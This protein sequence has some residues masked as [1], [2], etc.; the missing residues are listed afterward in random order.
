MALR[1]RGAT[2]DPTQAGT[3]EASARSASPVAASTESARRTASAS[4]SLLAPATQRAPCILHTYFRRA[5]ASRSDPPATSRFRG[6]RHVRRDDARSA[7][8]RDPDRSAPRIRRFEVGARRLPRHRAMEPRSRPSA[9]TAAIANS[10]STR[11]RSA[12]SRAS[13]RRGAIATTLRRL[14]LLHR[15]R[16]PRDHGHRVARRVVRRRDRRVV[17]IQRP[18]VEPC[19]SLDAV[20][21]ALRHRLGAANR[22]AVTARDRRPPLRNTALHSPMP[23]GAMGGWQGDNRRRH[24][25]PLLA[26]ARDRGRHA[27]VLGV[28]P[29]A[30]AHRAGHAVL[31]SLA[32][33]RTH[34]GRRSQSDACILHTPSRRS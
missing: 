24:L 29:H 27:R 31:R 6:H 21:R 7:G 16:A 22:D 4:I 30:L 13:E 33:R 23:G 20:G 19:L 10:A 14:G 2:I 28:G 15:R 11:S 1:E 25:R 34:S 3:L 8:A 5:S 26:G 32:P 18:E 17:L 9:S 12:P